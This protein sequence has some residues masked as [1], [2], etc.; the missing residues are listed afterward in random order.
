MKAIQ[1]SIN[2]WIDK[3]NMVYTYNGIL[4]SLK[5]EGNSEKDIMLSEISQSQKDKYCMIL[6][7]WGTYNSQIH[8]V[9]KNGGTSLVAQWLRIPL[10]TQGTQVQSL[11]LEDPT[12]RGATKPVCHKYWACALEPMS[13]N[14]WACVPQLLK[15]MC[16]EPT[17]RNKRSHR[18][19][20]PA[21][22]NEG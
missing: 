22:R 18:N 4:F 12:C 8:R 1:V 16:L 21:H 7:I 17:F 11:V 14:Y 6:F 10:P 5:K 15:P 9:K 19:E 3:Q 2:G 20:K 13:H